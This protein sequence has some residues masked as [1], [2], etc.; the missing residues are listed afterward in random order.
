MSIPENNELTIHKT[1]ISTCFFTIY[2]NDIG[3]KTLEIEKYFYIY[4]QEL[5]M[6]MDL[7]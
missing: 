1:K 4:I 6:K 7:K 5:K 2:D 3:Q